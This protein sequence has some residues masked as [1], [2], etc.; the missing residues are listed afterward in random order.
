MKKSEFRQ[1][2]RKSAPQPE[3]VVGRQSQRL[4][5]WAK[6]FSTV[7]ALLSAVIASTIGSAFCCCLAVST[8]ACSIFSLALDLPDLVDLSARLEMNSS[9]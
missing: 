2:R 1:I 9:F 3:T 7:V 6:L 8:T 4:K 5:N